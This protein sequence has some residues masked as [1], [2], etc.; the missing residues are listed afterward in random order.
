[1]NNNYP[2]ILAAPPSTKPQPAT[3]ILFVSQRPL[4]I[5]KFK[6]LMGYCQK[7]AT[8]SWIIYIDRSQTPTL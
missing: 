3:S 7:L 6:V 1:M 2:N 8:Y 4:L 5:F